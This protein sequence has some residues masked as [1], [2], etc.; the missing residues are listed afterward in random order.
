MLATL[1]AHPLVTRPFVALL[2]VASTQV[3]CT[4]RSW[5]SESS[6]PTPG[7]LRCDQASECPTGYGCTW[8]VCMSDE[9]NAVAT[10]GVCTDA[11]DCGAGMQCR[12]GACVATMSQCEIDVECGFGDICVRGRCTSARGSRCQNDSHCPGSRCVQRR[13]L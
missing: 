3:G 10:D 13:C 5:S 6:T 11:V 2:A 12:G 9:D 1:R 4:P 8:G 7:F